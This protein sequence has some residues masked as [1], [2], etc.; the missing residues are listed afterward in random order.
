VKNHTPGVACDG[1]K[2]R[3]EKLNVTRQNNH[4]KTALI[5]HALNG[6]SGKETVPKFAIEI[7]RRVD[8]QL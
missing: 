4:M 8:W 5:V 2:S 7:A 3:F 6:G 1:F